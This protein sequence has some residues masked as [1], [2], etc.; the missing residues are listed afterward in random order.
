M[1]SAMRETRA[2]E[3]PSHLKSK[4]NNKASAQVSHYTTTAMLTGYMH[5]KYASLIPNMHTQ[6]TPTSTKSTNKLVLPPLHYSTFVITWCVQGYVS[7][8]LCSLNFVFVVRA[9]TS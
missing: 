1:A 9:T 5:Y 7:L 6:Q 3:F 2:L 8:S 4:R